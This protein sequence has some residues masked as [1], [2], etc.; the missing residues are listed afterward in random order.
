MGK[1]VLHGHEL[2]ATNVTDDSSHSV[3]RPCPG[4]GADCAAESMAAGADSVPATWPAQQTGAHSGSGA[5]STRK[6]PWALPK[7]LRSLC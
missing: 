6:E 5:R 1:S 3:R 7:H 4:A 2:V